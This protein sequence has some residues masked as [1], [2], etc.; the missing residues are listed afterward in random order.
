MCKLIIPFYFVFFNEEFITDSWLI[1]SGTNDKQF[2]C[3]V[4]LHS[5]GFGGSGGESCNFS[6]LLWN[7]QFLGPFWS[8]QGQQVPGHWVNGIHKD[9]LT[10][11][12]ARSLGV[13][14]Q[15]TRNKIFT[16]QSY[17]PFKSCLRIQI[18]TSKWF[19]QKCCYFI[20]VL[21]NHLVHSRTCIVSECKPLMFTCFY[22]TFSG[23]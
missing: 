10:S 4:I 9:P 15:E 17:G 8:C 5:P 6:I 11:E 22:F 20:W 3:S 16:S 2:K 18:L 23:P 7:V 19:T 12:I 13:W 1:D 14:C 21:F